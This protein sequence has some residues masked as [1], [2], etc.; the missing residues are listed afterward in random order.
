MAQE[1]DLYQISRKVI[2]KN[3]DGKVLILNVSQ[4]GGAYVGFYDLPGGRIDKNEFAIPL[5]E[6]VKR[7]INEEIG[8]IQFKIK[9]NSVA[10]GRHCFPARPSRDKEDTHIFYVF[11]EAD[12]VSGEIKISEE[13]DGFEWIDLSTIDLEKYFTS[14]ILEGMKMYAEK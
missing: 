10:I 2:L 4:S 7:E 1:T 6:I 9:P 3:Q 5:L 13:H 12:F 8:D 11:Y 14:G